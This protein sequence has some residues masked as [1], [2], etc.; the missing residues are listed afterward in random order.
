MIREI[1]R[2]GLLEGGVSAAHGIWL[3]QSERQRMAGSGATIVHN[4]ASNLML[5]SGVMPMAKWR[6]LG[7]NLALGTDSANTGGRHDLFEAMRLAM[8]LP[9]LTVTE[10][11][12]WPTAAEILD[13]ATRSA[14]PVLGLAGRLGTIA[15]GQLADL[16]LVRYDQAAT[17]S[18][19]ANVAALL[20]VAS[21]A[22]VDSV[23]VDGRWLMRGQRILAFDEAAALREAAAASERIQEA[24]AEELPL[25]D[26]AL[27]G[28]TE[29]LRSRLSM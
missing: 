15:P 26:R 19:R 16:V 11:A 7:A 3:S 23:M 12:D 29:Q 28:I 10:H 18:M 22:A 13:M 2:Q 17:Q 24:V 8:M 21:P 4:P 27:P 14:A 1:D 6:G 5:G 25:L 20:Q 9:R